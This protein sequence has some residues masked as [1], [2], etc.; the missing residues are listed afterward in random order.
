MSYGGAG[1]RSRSPD[2]RCWVSHYSAS[3]FRSASGCQNSSSA[4]W[5]G[6][7][8]STPRSALS[9][10]SG[11]QLVVDKKGAENYYGEEVLGGKK[12]FTAVYADVAVS[13]ACVSCHNEHSDSPKTDFAL[14]DVMGG[15][16][17]RIPI[18]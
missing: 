1:W 13:K 15:V 6:G 10:S 5:A 17:I 14:N 4:G 18:N 11:L 3:S 9:Q 7:A 16:V 2:S 12:F 8:Q